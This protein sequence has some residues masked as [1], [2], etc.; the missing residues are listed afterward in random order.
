MN[1]QFDKMTTF[2][3]FDTGEVEVGM[4]DVE[5]PDLEFMQEKISGA[6][7]AGEV[8]LPT[9]GHLLSMTT[10]IKW[11][12]VTKESVVLVAPT[13]HDLEMRGAQQY[14]EGGGGNLGV[15]QIV[16][17]IRCLPKKMGLGK[18][19]VGIKTDTE[20]NF[21]TVYLKL[22]IDGKKVIEIDKFNYICYIS[23]TDWLADV[24]S[25]LGI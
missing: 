18:M 23:G 1:K 3:V 24:R 11:R 12:T 4:A 5:L 7:I 8:E 13:T 10:K 6:G 21:E 16:I 20:N 2:S 22:Q 19:G 25:A 9:L 15:Q 17:N 14:Y